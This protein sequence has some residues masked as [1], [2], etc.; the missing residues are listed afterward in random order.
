MRFRVFIF[1]FSGLKITKYFSIFMLNILV[2]AK[3]IKWMMCVA[4]EKKVQA[5]S[6]AKMK[7]VIF[8]ADKKNRYFRI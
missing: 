4:G 1:L 5:D 7:E 8:I 2:C 6:N 3:K